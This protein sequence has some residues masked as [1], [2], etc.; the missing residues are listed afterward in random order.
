MRKRIVSTLLLST[1]AISATGCAS[2]VDMTKEQTEL[3]A[4]YLASV[5]V[6]YDQNQNINKLVKLEEPVVMPTPVVVPTVAPTKEPSQIENV[7][8]MENSESD[9]SG[10]TAIDKMDKITLESLYGLKNISITYKN[11]KEYSIYPNKESSNVISASAGK[12]FLAVSFTIKNNQKE[13]VEVNLLQHKVNFV[14][15]DSEG[16]L[17]SSIPTLLDEDMTYY[18]ETCKANSTQ[19]VVVLFEVDKSYQLSQQATFYAITE[20]NKAFEFSIK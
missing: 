7:I 8:T 9:S 20:D 12:K 2:K 15:K 18:H 1:L 14:L 16:K 13:D 6:K 17:H 3:V 11:V 5:I 10:N 4:D 19:N